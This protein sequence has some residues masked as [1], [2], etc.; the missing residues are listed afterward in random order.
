MNKMMLLHLASNDK[1]VLVNP[2]NIAFAVVMEGEEQTFTRIFFKQIVLE[3]ES[4]WVDG[5]ETP[6]EIR[7][8]H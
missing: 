6:G 4:K 2:E 8:I 1:E 7:R 3:D 5:K